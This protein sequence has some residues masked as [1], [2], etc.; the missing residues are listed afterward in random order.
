M[1]TYES[2]FYPLKTLGSHVA[3]FKERC[4]YDRTGNIDF[5]D[6]EREALIELIRSNPETIENRIEQ[7]F[8]N[9]MQNVYILSMC[10]FKDRQDLIAALLTEVPGFHLRHLEMLIRSVF[11]IEARFPDDSAGDEEYSNLTGGWYGTDTAL[12][13][14]FAERRLTSQLIF[15]RKVLRS[16][17]IMGSTHE[18]ESIFE[19]QWLFMT[20]AK[21]LYSVRIPATWHLAW[22]QADDL[23]KL[24][25]KIP[26]NLSENA[27][28]YARMKAQGF[29]A[30]F[31]RVTD[32]YRRGNEKP[33]R[34]E[35]RRVYS[36]GPSIMALAESGQLAGFDY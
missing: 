8:T 23:W 25:E 32:R 14:W 2:K 4:E 27:V 13:K 3:E 30:E 1:Y 18:K 9:G 24:S 6:E 11:T 36:R 20:A 33:N 5:T 7:F 29:F 19:A 15:I 16:F 22:M 17:R 31:H 28:R 34:H 10:R 26:Q 21:L 12:G 35:L